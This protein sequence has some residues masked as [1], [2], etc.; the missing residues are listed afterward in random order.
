MI[1]R[2]KKMVS[3]LTIV[4]LLFACSMTT[5]AKGIAT[6]NCDSSKILLSEMIA[7]P[8]VIN[9]YS[10]KYDEVVKEDVK[11]NLESIFNEWK[12]TSLRKPKSVE[13]QSIV[14]MPVAEQLLY[15][16]LND[17]YVE[18]MDYIKAIHSNESD[19]F[20]YA[21]CF[22]FTSKNFFGGVNENRAYCFAGAT[23]D[24]ELVVTEIDEME[25]SDVTIAAASTINFSGA[26]AMVYAYPEETK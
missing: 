9:D 2:N 6:V 15:D 4:T 12:E 10:D 21:V 8:A 24:G 13:L 3:V 19:A 22:E 26:Q 23:E 17:S 18:T 11:V 1:R 7:Y 16:E 25:A 20:Q 5:F 14:A